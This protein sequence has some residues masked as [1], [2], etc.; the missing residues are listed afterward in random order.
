MLTVGFS[1]TAWLVQYLI[2]NIQTLLES[3]LQYFVIYFAA[4]GV[5]SFTVCYYK[6]PV[7]NPRLHVIIKW[8]IQLVAI[9]LIYISSYVPELSATIFIVIVILSYLP[10]RIKLP[11]TVST[12][13]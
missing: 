8:V 12:F 6:G 13:W 3:Y 7:T 9:G 10:R 11:T 1:F 4:A 2:Q 5:I